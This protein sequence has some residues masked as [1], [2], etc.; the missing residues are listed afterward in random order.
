MLHPVGKL[1]AAVYWRRRL[2]LLALVV[3]VLGGGAWL[4][5]SLLAEQHGRDGLLRFYR[6]VGRP[7]AAPTA[8]NDAF[9]QMWGS[10]LAEFTA[11]W[12]RDLMTRL[13]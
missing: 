11:Q 4:A 5:V 7:G 2:L 13:R 8:V 1:P 3:A 6:L 9:R 12:R 10:S